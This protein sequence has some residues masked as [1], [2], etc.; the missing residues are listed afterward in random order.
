MG[1]GTACWTN[2]KVD[3]PG[4][5]TSRNTAACKTTSSWKR[6]RDR[7]VKIDIPYVTVLKDEVRICEKDFN[8]QRVKGKHIAP[9][10]IEIAAMG[11]ADPA[12]AAQACQPDALASV[13][14]NLHK[15]LSRKG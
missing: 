1:I 6:L 7:T 13:R 8:P 10:T 11:G 14:R 2:V 15:C 12:R 9:H 5:R 4:T 3:R